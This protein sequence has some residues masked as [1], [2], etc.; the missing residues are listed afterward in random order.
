MST[1]FATEIFSDARLTLIAVECVDF[2][3]SK[4][5]T[6]YRMYG[7]IKPI[8]VIVCGPDATYALDI[9]AKPTDVDLLRQD[10][11][12]LDAIIAHLIIHKADLGAEAKGAE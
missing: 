12:E 5:N 3:S 9:E 8:A 1:F 4:T 7:N 11:P 10:I 6:C 2:R